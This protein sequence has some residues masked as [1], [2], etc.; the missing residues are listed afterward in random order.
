MCVFAVDRGKLFPESTVRNITIQVMNGLAFMHKHGQPRSAV[1]NQL[2]TVHFQLKY[3]SS[4]LTA[5]KNTFDCW[6]G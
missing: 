1:V 4:V 3:I 5:N 2:F 6:T